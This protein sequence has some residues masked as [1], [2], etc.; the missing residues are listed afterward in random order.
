MTS[1]ARTLLN[2]GLVM[3]LIGLLLGF[4]L[5]VFLAGALDLRPLPIVFEITL[6]GSERGWR[7]AHIGA[8]VNGIF[9]A[10]L[11]FALD[12]SELGSRSRSWTAGLIVFAIWA[13]LAFYL[14]AN[15]A[16][17]RGLSWGDNAQG[18]ETLFGILAF[19][20]AALGS[21]AALIALAV[22]I[23]GSFSAEKRQKL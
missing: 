19:A 3:M 5:L 15:L 16:P 12:K 11:S 21:V 7:A 22:L 18:E 14:F 8:L 17:N 23:R 13:N 10:S 1:S 4:A 6:P 9:A 20:P 2:H